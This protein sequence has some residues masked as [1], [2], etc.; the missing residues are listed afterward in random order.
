MYGHVW[1]SIYKTDEFLDYTKKAWI[2]GLMK[3]EDKSIEH[4]LQLCLKKCPLPPTL[5]QF[6][7]CCKAHQNTDVF[8]QKQESVQK[9]DLT[10]AEMHLNKMRTILNMKLQQKENNHD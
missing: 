9:A 1:R 10:M 6:I 2:D 5:P 8:Y 3:F 4:A 7:E